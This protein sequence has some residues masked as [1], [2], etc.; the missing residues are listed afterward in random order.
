V[1]VCFV[2]ELL[3]LTFLW[4]HGEQMAKFAKTA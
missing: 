3:F 4:R 1:V 2:I